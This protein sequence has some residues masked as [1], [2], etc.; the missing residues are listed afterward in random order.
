M[1]TDVI[2][3]LDLSSSN[4]LEI[5]LA[6]YNTRN[7]NNKEKDPR[8]RVESTDLIKLTTQ[9][10]ELKDSAFITMLKGK[11]ID[12]ASKASVF[13][14]DEIFFPFIPLK[15]VGNFFGLKPEALSSFVFRQLHEFGRWQ[16]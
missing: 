2:T 5:K 4:E 11:L 12:L 15:G 13:G 8:Q 7:P 10:A 14:F 16:T 3:N 1:L 6:T 9:C